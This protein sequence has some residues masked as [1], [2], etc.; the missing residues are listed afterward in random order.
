MQ[1]E[2]INK[3]ISKTQLAPNRLKKSSDEKQNE[4][5]NKIIHNRQI[6]GSRQTNKLKKSSGSL[7]ESVLG[8]SVIAMFG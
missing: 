2:Q 7:Y 3:M 1:I 8:V 5:I 4:Q 6:A